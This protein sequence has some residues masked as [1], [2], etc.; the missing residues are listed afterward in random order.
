MKKKAVNTFQWLIIIAL[1]VFF[2]KTPQDKVM[3]LVVKGVCGTAF[4]ILLYYVGKLAIKGIKKYRYLHSSIHHIDNMTGVQFE[5]CLKA[6]FEKLG[7]K[8]DT[9]PGSGDYGVDLICKKRNEKFVVQAKRYTGKIGIS[10]VQQVIGG[11]HYYDCEKGMV[12]TNSYF[13]KNAQELAEKSNVTLWDRT[14]LT[15]NFHI[16]REE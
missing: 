10:A 15:K 7:Y 8:V 9:T 11:M 14:V 13:T 2:F 6:H 5:N 12:V 3:D 1:A 4:F 16:R